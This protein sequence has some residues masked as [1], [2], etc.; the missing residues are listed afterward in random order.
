MAVPKRKMSRSNTRHRRSQWKAVAPAPNPRPTRA[1]TASRSLVLRARLGFIMKTGIHPDYV[2][3]RVTCTFTTSL[4]VEVE[5]GEAFIGR[6]QP[7]MPVE[8]SRAHQIEIAAHHLP[9]RRARGAR[10]RRQ[11]RGRGDA[12]DRGDPRRRAGRAPRGLHVHERRPGHPDVHRRRPGG[13]GRPD[14]RAVPV[15][16]GAARWSPSV[17]GLVRTP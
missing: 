9:G 16:R 15:H 12:G 14:G 3:S 10:P 13:P 7:K 2:E 5:V 11:L 1:T 17:V 4:E 6:V 8:A